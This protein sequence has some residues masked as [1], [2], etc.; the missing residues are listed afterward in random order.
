MNT[1]SDIWVSFAQT[2]GMLFVVLAAF[3]LLFYLFKRFSGVSA[4]KGSRDLIKVLTVHHLAP[5]EKL[6]LVSVLDE[7]ML[8][9]VTSSNITKLAR[10]D[11]DP[12]LISDV[13]GGGGFSDLLGRALKQKTGNA[14]FNSGAKRDLEKDEKQNHD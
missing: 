3:I 13:H 8:L 2:F 10:L 1:D 4:G 14:D 11:R 5:K 7:V 12:D 6:V 9:G